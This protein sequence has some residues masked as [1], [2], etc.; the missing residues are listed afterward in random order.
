MLKKCFITL[1]I[2]SITI[3]GFAQDKIKGNKNVTIVETKIDDFKAISF[4]E[5]FEIE[6]VQ[7][8]DPSVAIETDE[9]LHE[10]IE[11]TVTDSVLNFRTLLK[12]QYQKQLK[13][14]VNYTTKLRQILIN[15][16]AEISAVGTIKNKDLELRINDYSKA[17]LNVDN[18]NFKLI[19]NNTSTF[20]INS[21]SK[22]NIESDYV[23][24]EL[25]ENSKTEALIVTDS[26]Q[27]EMY[28]S[29]F[30][31]IEGE[32]GF[33]NLLT[34]NSSEFSA[35]NLS[36]NTC[37]ISTEESSEATVQVLDEILIETSGSSEIYLYGDP[38]INLNA[39]RDSSS[40]YK[41]K[42]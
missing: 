19:N 27:V 25:N 10:V 42:L 1:F 2:I 36:A 11:F 26:L 23:S 16:D 39:F 9:N 14:T 30:A 33:L 31:K 38:K 18:Q 24:L 3:T 21:K 20:G 41:K 17:Y 34:I 28:Q 13:I 8:N 35:K 6:L 12:I 32:T 29:A 40:I 4:G 37:K 22:L 15:D 7:S 5:K